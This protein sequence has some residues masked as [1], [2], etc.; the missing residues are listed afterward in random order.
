VIVGA[1]DRPTRELLLDI[2]LWGIAFVLLGAS[3]LYLWFVLPVLLVIRA[4]RW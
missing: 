4:L 3:A 2:V 1:M